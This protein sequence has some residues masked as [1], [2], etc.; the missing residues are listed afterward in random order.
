MVYFPLGVSYL[1]KK[2]FQYN[3][4]V[5]AL[6]S[7]DVRLVRKDFNFWPWFGL[8]IAKRFGEDN[9]TLKSENQTE[10][11][12]INKSDKIENS[13]ISQNKSTP[14]NII[15]ARIGFLFPFIG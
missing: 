4:N 12:P 5:G 14:Y 1:G 15:S 11:L 8:S 2:N 10:V 6:Y 3:I 13:G 9:K 7:K